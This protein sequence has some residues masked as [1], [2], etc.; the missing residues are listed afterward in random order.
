MEESPVRR[1]LLPRA[2]MALAAGF[3]AAAVLGLVSVV[4]GHGAPSPSLLAAGPLVAVAWI[5]FLV[6]GRRA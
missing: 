4:S 2:L 6:A 5:V 1:A 3:T